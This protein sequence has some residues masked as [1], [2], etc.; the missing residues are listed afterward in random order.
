MVCKHVIISDSRHQLNWAGLKLNKYC[1]LHVF[2]WRIYAKIIYCITHH[3]HLAFQAISVANWTS[4]QVM[5]WSTTNKTVTELLTWEK[6]TFK[7]ARS[8]WSINAVTWYKEYGVTLSSVCWHKYDNNQRN[9]F[10]IPIQTF[11]I[12]VIC[13]FFKLVTTQKYENTH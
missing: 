10:F 4:S 7:F 6:R 12:N 9:Y 3:I 11:P 5:F 1:V 8:F 2:H 13:I